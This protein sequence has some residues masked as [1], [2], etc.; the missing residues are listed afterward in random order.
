MSDLL[1][2]LFSEE[3]P[4]RMQRKAAADLR[5]CVTNQLVDAGLTY[6][7]ACEYWTPRRLT[8]DIR[9][10]SLHSKDTHE[11]RKGPSTK[12]PQHVI[13]GFLR[14]TG[15]S[16]ISEADIAHDSKKGDFYIAKIIKKRAKRRRDYC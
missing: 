13:D 5:K 10:L 7:A 9:G 8:L 11:E 6:Q 2:E 1:L 15:L 16:D 3:I 4:A 14:S 12:S